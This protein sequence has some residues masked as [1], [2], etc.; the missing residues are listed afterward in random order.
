MSESKKDSVQVKLTLEGPMKDFL[1][2]EAELECRKITAHIRYI[3]NHYYA[4]RMRTMSSQ[5]GNVTNFVGHQ[6][7]YNESIVR[8]MNYN[9]P[10]VPPTN[11]EEQKV[12]ATNMDEQ[13][14]DKYAPESDVSSPQKDVL[15]GEDFGYINSDALDF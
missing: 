2:K 7:N 15:E 3:V 11:S 6:S 8:N 10:I 9:E 13:E 5:M 4:E 1:E 12:L 14:S